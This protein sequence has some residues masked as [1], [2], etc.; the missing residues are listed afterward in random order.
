MK[1]E[2]Y[3]TKGKFYRSTVAKAFPYPYSNNDR[4]FFNFRNFAHPTKSKIP[5]SP[6]QT[7]ISQ[8]SILNLSKF[9][10]VLF[11]YSSIIFLNLELLVAVVISIYDLIRSLSVRRRNVGKKSAKILY[12][13]TS[14]GIS[15]KINE[16]VYISI[17]TYF[18]YLKT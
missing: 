9:R 14:A 7:T 5:K 1:S 10:E 17:S 18:N 2:R 3:E 16:T 13:P 4:S 6:N 15:Y 8:P 11:R 12:S